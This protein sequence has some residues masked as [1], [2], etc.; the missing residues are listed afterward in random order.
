VVRELEILYK[1]YGYQL[2]LMGDSLLNAMVTGI[3]NAFIESG[4]TLYW[5]GYLRADKPV[6]DID[7]TLL[8]RRGGYYRAR[9]GL[10]SGSQKVLDAMNK[11]ITTEQ[12][13]AAVS[14]LAYAGIKTTTYWVIG[15]HGE[16]EDDFQQ[17]LSL[18]EELESNIYEAECNPFNYFPSGQ[19]NSGKWA[20]ENK[21][22]PLYPGAEDMLMLHTWVLDGPP[23]RRETY[24]RITR[25]VEHC[26][27]LGI[28][29]PYSIQNI[30]QAD[31]RWKQLHQNAVPP[32]VDFKNTNN[33]I[34]E[35]RDVK[36]L[37]LVPD[38]PGS[39]HDE[40]GWDFVS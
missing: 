36:K 34:D 14:A 8:W 9:L 19:V 15:Y 24:H 28:P 5:D 38:V 3:A 22:I 10:E 20:N 11:M 32:L 4:K 30:Y 1:Q 23:T 33:Y 39:H 16:T 18:L 40:E 7:N 6:C 2:F 21:H 12:I 17:T 35:A 27:K 25:F 29:N 37:L 13:K 26:R 31:Q